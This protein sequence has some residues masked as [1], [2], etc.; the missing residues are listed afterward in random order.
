M[1]NPV[2]FDIA[3]G[4]LPEGLDTDP[5]GLLEAFA[6]RLI[7]SPSV[8]WS[9]FVLG[10][11]QP[12]SDLGPWAKDGQTWWMWS[13]T[14]ATYVPQVLDPVSLGYVVST[15]NPGAASYTLWF[16]TTAKGIKYSDGATWTD[17][18]TGRFATELAPY[19]TTTAMNA[20]IAAAI[21]ALPASTAGRGVFLAKPSV[22]QDVVFGGA[23][24][25]NGIVALGSESFDPDGVFAANTF[26]APADGYY[27]FN[28]AL[29]IE[30]SGGTP[31]DLDIAAQVCIG[32]VAQFQV[33]DEPGPDTTNGRTATGSGV[34][35]LT[36]GQTVDL[37]YS[38]TTDAAVT[39]EILPTYTKLDGFRVR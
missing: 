1:P 33:N 10:A 17:I 7:I 25:A 13:D 9:S 22:Q 29:Q 5:Q 2:T 21:A 39:V 38:F 32:G 36:L 37:R 8:P 3:V 19:S 4:S 23:G 6:A 14:L 24:T 31:T 18:L 27:Q 15:T 11:A 16:D 35:F 28:A 12:T 20:A 30:T 26:T 34:L